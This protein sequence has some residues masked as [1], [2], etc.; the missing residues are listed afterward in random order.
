MK[1]LYVDLHPADDCWKEQFRDDSLTVVRIGEEMDGRV[2]H[3]SVMVSRANALVLQAAQALYKAT[4]AEN[5]FLTPSDE[6]VKL[7]MDALDKAEGA[8]VGTRWEHYIN[9]ANPPTPKPEAREE[10]IA[11]VARDL[12]AWATTTF[13]HRGKDHFLE[14]EN[15][16]QCYIVTSDAITAL[17]AALSRLAEKEGQAAEILRDI[18]SRP[19]FDEIEE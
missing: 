13:R 11:T 12:I 5:D 9:H 16:E 4:L 19:A 8:T 17:K 14:D 7:G 1:E 15:G 3:S 6:A 2:H 10:D 18:A